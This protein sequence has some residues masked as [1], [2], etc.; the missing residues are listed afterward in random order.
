MWD[1]SPGTSQQHQVPATPLQQNPTS[2]GTISTPS[3]STGLSSG[4][5]REDFVWASNPTPSSSTN[6]SPAASTSRGSMI[7]STRGVRCATNTR[8]RGAIMRGH[9]TRN[10]MAR[11]HVGRARGPSRT[12]GVRGRSLRRKN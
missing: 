6:P 10:A 11:G 5:G 12:P 4:K 7:Y 9:P 3:A 1:Q 8:G 2:S